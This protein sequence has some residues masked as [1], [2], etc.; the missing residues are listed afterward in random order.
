MRHSSRYGNNILEAG[1]YKNTEV[2]HATDNSTKKVRIN[3]QNFDGK[4]DPQAS[5]D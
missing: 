2:Q 5:T 3:V 4:I 1:R